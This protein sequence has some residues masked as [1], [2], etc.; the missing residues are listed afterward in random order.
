V[1]L[2]KRFGT[3]FYPQTQCVRKIKAQYDGPKSLMDP[4]LART[5][6]T[7]PRSLKQPEKEKHGVQ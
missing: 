1:F 7:L 5:T 4:G 6:S 2:I 3:F